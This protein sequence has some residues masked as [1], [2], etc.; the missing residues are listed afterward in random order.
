MPTYEAVIGL[1]THIQPRKAKEGSAFRSCEELS[2]A[3]RRGNPLSAVARKP[4]G[5]TKQSPT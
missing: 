3:R 4:E 1:E 2:A 5:L